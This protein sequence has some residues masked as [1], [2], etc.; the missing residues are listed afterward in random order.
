MRLLPIGSMV[1]WVW[2]LLAAVPRRTANV[3][4]LFLQATFRVKIAYLLL[5]C[6]SV[7]GQVP[8]SEADLNR[9]VSY[10][11]TAPQFKMPPPVTTSAF[12]KYIHAK[13]EGK[14]L[15]DP[16]VDELVLKVL[17]PVLS[18]YER[19]NVYDLV[20]ID[21]P[22]S[23]MMSHSGVVLV[24]TTGMIQRAQSD[25][26]LLGYTA[27]EVAHE[28][29][30]MYTLYSRYLITVAGE[31]LAL[32]TPPVEL[33]SLV[34][35]QCDAFAVL[36]LNRLGYDSLEIISGMERTTRD[37]RSYISPGHPPDKQRRRVIEA[38]RVPFK[39]RQ[40]KAFLQLKALVKSTQ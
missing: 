5:F 33:L 24:I 27:H 2:V 15:H 13:I 31:N 11:K 3:I 19:A 22:V 25:D 38:L 40:S 8:V 1:D 7:S 10:Y 36:T 20:V 17:E 14:R 21:S 23:M 34:E 26:E 32:K 9:T 16:K 35:L 18:L 4:R 30:V 37:F 39:P 6:V 29:F 12:R 28:Y